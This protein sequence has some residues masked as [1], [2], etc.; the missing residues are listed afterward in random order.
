MKKGIKTSLRRFLVIKTLLNGKK[1]D[2]Q[3]LLKKIN[4]TYFFR[5][6]QEYSLETEEMNLEKLTDP[7][8]SKILKD[9][10]E[11]K[12]I[13]SE[14]M[15]QKSGRGPSG[16]QHWL[17]NDLEVYFEVLLEFL[18][19]ADWLEYREIQL[20]LHTYNRSIFLNS[21]YG[22]KFINMDLFKFFKSKIGIDVNEKSKRWVLKILKISPSAL[23]TFYGYVMGTAEYLELFHI[24]ADD[25]TKEIFLSRIVSAFIKDLTTPSFWTPYPVKF[26]SVFIIDEDGNEQKDPINRPKFIFNIEENSLKFDIISNGVTFSK[27]PP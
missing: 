3:S 5:F 10:R 16:Y 9:M 13:E 24:V 11:D 7:M 15:P 12:I 14:P 4:S 20:D 21:V 25:L 8:L 19:F 26:K 1:W 18:S 2:T 22:Q 6:Q 17:V 27:N 23:K